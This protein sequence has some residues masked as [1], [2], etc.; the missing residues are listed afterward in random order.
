MH[1]LIRHLAFNLQP[2]NTR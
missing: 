2:Q 1:Q